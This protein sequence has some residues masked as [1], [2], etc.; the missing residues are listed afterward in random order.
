MFHLTTIDPA[1]VKRCNQG[2]D[3]EKCSWYIGIV[4]LH[5]QRNN[6]MA[7]EG[8]KLDPRQLKAIKLACITEY[9]PK[10]SG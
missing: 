2:A 9:R 8:N 10:S 5:S 3:Q 1:I 4:Y 7:K 6:V